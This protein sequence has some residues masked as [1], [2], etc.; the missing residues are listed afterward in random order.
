M[1]ECRFGPYF[2]EPVVAGI[3]DAT[4]LNPNP[5]PFISTMDT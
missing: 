3:P 2:I 5:K 1:L 4:P